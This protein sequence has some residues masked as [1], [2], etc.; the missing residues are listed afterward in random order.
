M[1]QLHSGAR[2][3]TAVLFSLTFVV[4]LF[5]LYRYL[6]TAHLGSPEIVVGIGR[7]ITMS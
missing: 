1:I 6:R 7:V 3:I 4:L 2:A 5:E